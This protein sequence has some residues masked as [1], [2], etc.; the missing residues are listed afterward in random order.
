MLMDTITFGPAQTGSLCASVTDTSASGLVAAP[1][2]V[3]TTSPP[4]LVTAA[5]AAAPPPDSVPGDSWI[6]LGAKPKALISSTPSDPEPWSLVSVCGRRGS[7]SSRAPHH[8]IQLENKFAPLTFPPVEEPHRSPPPSPLPSQGSHGSPS[9]PRSSTAIPETLCSIPLFTPAPQSAPAPLSVHL[10]P[11]TSSPLAKSPPPTAP[12][13]SSSPETPHSASPRPL[14]PLTTLKIGDSIT[15]NIHFFN[16]VA[17]HFF[18]GASSVDHFLLMA[19]GQKSSPESSS[20]TPGSC[21]S[22]EHSV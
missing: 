13:T 6:H 21:L 5:A 9:P 4:R 10:S 22:A 7:C 18:P 20:S 2:A 15:R 8:N 3:K 12:S 14:F 11:A 1:K 17:A 19:V 16:A